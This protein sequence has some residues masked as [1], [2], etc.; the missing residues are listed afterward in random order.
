MPTPAAGSLEERVV[1]TVLKRHDN[2]ERLLHGAPGDY[3]PIF[4]HHTGRLYV[5]DW[6]ISFA[7]G[8][9]LSAEA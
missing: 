5:E 2:V 4:M 1:H 8:V 9:S 6:A 7:R 3:C